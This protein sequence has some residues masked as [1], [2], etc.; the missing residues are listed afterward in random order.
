[1]WGWGWGRG[2]GVGV[3]LVERGSV[4]V[5][6]SKCVCPEEYSNLQLFANGVVKMSSGNVVT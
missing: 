1:M 5:K 2:E 6:L 3:K 4:R